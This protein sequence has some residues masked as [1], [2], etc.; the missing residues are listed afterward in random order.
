MPLGADARLLPLPGRKGLMVQAHW[1]ATAASHLDPPT[2]TLVGRPLWRARQD[3]IDF[4]GQALAA[5]LLAD[6]DRFGLAAH[7]LAKSAVKILA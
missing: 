6:I 1:S 7:R 5:L 3:L 2:L 4:H